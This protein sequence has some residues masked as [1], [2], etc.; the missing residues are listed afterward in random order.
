[1]GEVRE[2]LTVCGGQVFAFSSQV[3][4][5][6]IRDVPVTLSHTFQSGTRSAEARQP[7]FYASAVCAGHLSERYSTYMAISFPRGK[8]TG[9]GEG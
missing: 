8:I 6:L 5:S 4:T 2:C 1:M 9:W 3:M 7:E